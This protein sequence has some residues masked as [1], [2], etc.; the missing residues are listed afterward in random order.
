MTFRSSYSEMIVFRVT[1]ASN[2]VLTNV[3][4]EGLKM[5]YI[6]VVFVVL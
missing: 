3:R 6:D 2:V 5:K 1:S 4:V